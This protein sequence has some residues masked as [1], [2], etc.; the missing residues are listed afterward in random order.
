MIGG[1]PRSGSQERRYIIPVSDFAPFRRTLLSNREEAFR[2]PI[3]EGSLLHTPEHHAIDLGSPRIDPSP[4]SAPQPVAPVWH[5]VILIAGIVLMSI[6][7]AAELTGPHAVINRMQTYTL[8]AS[9]ELGMLAWVYFGL[10]LR[11][12]PFRSLFGSISGNLP[13]V[14]ADFGLATLFWIGS[15]FTLA[16][17][18]VF[19]TLTEAVIK[20]RPLITPGKQLTPD[21]TQQQ[22]IHTLTQ[23]A[24]SNGREV[25]AW[26][27]LCLIAGVA[28]EVVFRGYLHRQFTA[29]ARGA[30][31]VGVVGSALFFGAAHGYQGA[32][33]MVLLAVFGVLFSLLAL[34]RRS[35][36]PGIFAHAWHDLF[37][38]LVLAFLKA[39]HK[40]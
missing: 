27:C 7:G 8:T 30:V 37:A 32:R 1:S 20:H 24:P 19:W 40:L 6:A 23:L 4:E 15:L 26:I 35:L 36:R 31:A 22:T 18:G 25:A 3:E 5:S 10:R 12:V 14:A 38:G 33:S 9:T 17:I 11:K 28:E 21:P 29:W 34:F 39:H 2:Q 16:T 13:S